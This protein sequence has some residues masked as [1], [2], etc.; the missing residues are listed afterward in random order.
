MRNKKNKLS[1]DQ[2]KV[3]LGKTKDSLDLIS[4]GIL[5]ACHDEPKPNYNQGGGHTDDDDMDF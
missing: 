1:L 3:K 2:F 5:G 4:G